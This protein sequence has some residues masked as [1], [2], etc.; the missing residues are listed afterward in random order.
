MNAER[1]LLLL[2]AVW[3]L[4]GCASRSDVP[5]D[6]YYRLAT[7]TPVAGA[8]GPM[9]QGRLQVDRIEAFGVYRDRAIVYVSA[10]EPRALRHHHYHFWVAPPTDLVRDQLAEYLRRARMAETVSTEAGGRREADLV[11]AAQLTN[12]E[13]QFLPTGG[14]QAVVGLRVTIKRG[15]A[16]LLQ[17]SFSATDTAEDASFSASVRAFERALARVYADLAAD[18]GRVTAAAPRGGA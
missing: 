1:A 16:I 13:R 14:V 17:R 8:P 18:L 15:G 2:A 9:L 11:L 3:V 7:P 12:F 4:A 10:D 6:R 5:D